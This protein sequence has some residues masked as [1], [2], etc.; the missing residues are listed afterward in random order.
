MNSSQPLFTVATITYNSGKWVRHAIESVLASTF[1]DFE[2]LISDDCSTDDTWAIIEQYNDPRIRSWKNEKNIG[3][4]PNRNK[5]LKEAKG[6]Y[7]YYIDGDDILYKSTL[8][9]LSEYV[10][11]FPEA[12][13]IWGIP[14]Y[15]FIVF[16]VLFTPEEIFRIEFLGNYY[17]SMIGFPETIFKKDILLN[18]GGFNEKYA[19]EITILK[20]IVS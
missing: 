9:N 8:R 1:I 17:W 20:K 12:G 18:A 19:W 10:Y 3:E 13:M 16:P 15:D 7:I 4:Y 5:V 6:K 14:H 11:G 2:Y